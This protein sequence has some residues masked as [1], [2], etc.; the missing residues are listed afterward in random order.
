LISCGAG[1]S[2]AKP[3]MFPSQQRSHGRLYIH[4]PQRR[5]MSFS[6]RRIELFISEFARYTYRKSHDKN[7]AI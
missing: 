4:D 5:K 6:K 1:R 2:L 7:Y 3:A